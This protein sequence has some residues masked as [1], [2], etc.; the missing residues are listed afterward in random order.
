MERGD[1]ADLIVIDAEFA[2]A[3]ENGMD[4]K[5]GC[6]G[7]S[8]QLAQAGDELLLQFVGQTVLLPEEYDSSFADF[9]KV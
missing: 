4:V 1:G 7:S 3:V 9:D 6:G 8:S 5:G 2:R